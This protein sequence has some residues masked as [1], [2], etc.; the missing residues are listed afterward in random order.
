MHFSS[1]GIN[2]TMLVNTH[3]LSCSVYV[4]LFCGAGDQTQSL[5]CARQV[6]YR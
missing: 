6:L 5:M 4:W 2:L 3:T 1:T